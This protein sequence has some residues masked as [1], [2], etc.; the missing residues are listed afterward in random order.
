MDAARNFAARRLRPLIWPGALALSLLGFLLFG[1]SAEG[2][3]DEAVETP[4]A[5]LL[6]HA[7]GTEPSTGRRVV[8]GGVVTGVY[9]GREGLNGFFVQAGSQDTGLDSGLFVYAPAL[10]EG[11]WALLRPGT[12]VQ[13]EARFDEY[14]GWPQLHRVD[15]LRFC[16]E[17]GLPAPA[18][19]ELPLD[20]DALDRYR[21]LL[22]DFP[23]GLVVT[24]N[25]ELGRYGSLHLS[26]GKRL[27]RT[28]S[29]PA[30]A[31]LHQI[32]LDDGSYR[33]NPEPIPYLDE[34]HTR[35]AGDRV[36]ELQGVLVHAFHAWRVHPVGEVAFEAGNPRPQSPEFVTGLRLATLNLENY[37]LTLGQR[38]A[39]SPEALE[40]QRGKLLAT[41]RG[42]D[43]DLLALVELENSPGVLDDLLERL[44]A[45]FPPA[46]HYARPEGPDRQGGDAI[47][48]ALIYRP[49]RLEAMTPALP[50]GADVHNRTPVAAVFKPRRGGTPFLAAV[51]HHKAKSGCP[52]SGDVNRG[53]GCWNELRTQQSEALLAFVDQQ[54]ERHGVESVA[55]LGDFNSYA[56]EDPVRLLENAGYVNLVAQHLP[57]ERHYSYVFR[58]EAGMLD[59][60]FANRALARHISGA[61]VW[62]VNADEPVFLA[63][64]RRGGDAGM[65]LD[66]PW[67]SSDHD[68]VIVGLDVE[69]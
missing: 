15:A 1:H 59:Y 8:T 5:E 27:M 34:N 65:A 28:R 36:T 47:R 56:A 38:G 41:L 18:S 44:N 55:L 51:V 50:D 54:A 3:C 17:P 29:G 31:L 58:G 23:Q 52:T 30:D 24:G 4:L 37:F 10:T 14:R 62:H 16:G 68:P 33:S 6:G 42:L 19:L 48:V 2:G 35:R 69:H 67:R 45:E 66:A 22:V 40:R 13:L 26:A 25:Y 63:Y 12:R 60:V 46:E 57:E 20:P 64:D 21:G 7:N 61:T 11:Q 39:D 43:A 53:Q 49:G 32:V 9:P